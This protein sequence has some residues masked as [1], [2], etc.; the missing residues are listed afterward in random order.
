MNTVIMILRIDGQYGMGFSLL[1]YGL[2]ILLCIAL[3][4]FTM[5]YVILW[6]FLKYNKV[7]YLRAALFCLI[8]AVIL[9]LSYP[10]MYKLFGYF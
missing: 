10:I 9:H 2:I 1:Y 6:L 3:I 5:S 7:V 8:F 4:V